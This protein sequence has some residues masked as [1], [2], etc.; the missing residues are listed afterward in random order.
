MPNDIV[1]NYVVKTETNLLNPVVSK[2]KRKRKK[3]KINNRLRK[4]KV[5]NEKRDFSAGEEVLYK[6]HFRSYFKWL[7][8]KI[9]KRL[10]RYLYEI[11]VSY[12]N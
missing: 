2:D 4:E 6:N 12:K 7:S 10:S 9:I 11:K 5:V 1:L 3:N 8:A